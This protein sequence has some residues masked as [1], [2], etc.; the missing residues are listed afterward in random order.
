MWSVT[1]M[2]AQWCMISMFAPGECNQ[3]P[4]TNRQ[5]RSLLSLHDVQLTLDQT[6]GNDSKLTLS[7]KPGVDHVTAIWTCEYNLTQ[8]TGFAVTYSNEKN[9]HYDSPVLEKTSRE[10]DLPSLDRDMTYTICVYVVGNASVLS[11]ACTNYNQDS[12]KIVVGIM[13]GVVFLIPCVIALI[14]LLRK[15]K[16]MMFAYDKLLTSSQTQPLAIDIKIS[17]DTLDSTIGVTNETTSCSN[18]GYVNTLC[19][20]ENSSRLQSCG[21]FGLNAINPNNFIPNSDYISPQGATS[22]LD[23]QLKNT[24]LSSTDTVVLSITQLS[25]MASQ[26]VLPQPTDEVFNSGKAPDP[27]LEIQLRNST[28]M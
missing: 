28:H 19:A 17:Q 6:P 10:F 14:W 23:R 4:V 22:N 20:E 18:Q 27:P 21:Q 7:V 15:D 5:R 11:H 24:H 16:K 8:F 2:L 25:V 26:S 12:M 3:F 13:A 1:M 9:E